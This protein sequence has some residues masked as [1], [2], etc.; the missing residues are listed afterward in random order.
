[1]PKKLN[2]NNITVLEAF[3][4]L[5]FDSK[6]ILSTLQLAVVFFDFFDF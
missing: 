4:T 3:A 2:I 5:Y 6:V 1:M